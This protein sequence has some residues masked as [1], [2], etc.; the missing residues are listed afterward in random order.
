MPARDGLVTRWIR[1]LYRN[2]WYVVCTPIY[3]RAY[4]LGFHWFNSTDFIDILKI[5]Y[6]QRDLKGVYVAT[7]TFQWHVLAAMRAA[8]PMFHIGADSRILGKFISYPAWTDFI[9]LNSRHT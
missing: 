5:E 1:S 9:S 7:D 8:L 3:C 6:S 4:L 2:K